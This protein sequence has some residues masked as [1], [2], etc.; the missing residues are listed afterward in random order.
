MYLLLTNILGRV[1]GVQQRNWRDY[2]VTF[3]PREGPQAQSRNFQRILTV[4]WD[5]RIP[6]IRIS[7]Q[8]ADTLQVGVT[9]RCQS[10]K[11]TKFKHI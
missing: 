1:V 7:T 11:T 3:P 2:V 5:H 10:C 4:P 9:S 8:Q 6:K